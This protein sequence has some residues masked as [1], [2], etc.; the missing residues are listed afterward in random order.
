M[1]SDAASEPGDGSGRTA[2]FVAPLELDDERRMR[3][4][5]ATAAKKLGVEATMQE[6]WG[7][8]G[9]T[10]AL[11]QLLQVTD[12]GNH[13]ELARHLARRAQHLTSTRVP[14]PVDWP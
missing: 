12:R 2:V 3:R 5:H 7:R 8:Q 1:S 11:A 6:S 9:R 13:T 14:A 10:V 4:A